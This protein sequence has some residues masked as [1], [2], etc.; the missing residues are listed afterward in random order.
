MRE[1]GKTWLLCLVMIGCGGCSRVPSI[2]FI[3]S[4]FPG[5]MFCIIGGILSAGL[6]HLGLARRGLEHKVSPLVVFYPSVATV[7]SCLLWLILF[8]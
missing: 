4:F 5:W 8:S 1:F 3:G 7:I 2:E 6:I